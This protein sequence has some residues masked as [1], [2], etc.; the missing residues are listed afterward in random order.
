MP[1]REIMTQKECAEELGCHV[2]TIARYMDG[3]GLEYIWL[4]GKRRITRGH[5]E[6]FL[7]EHTTTGPLEPLDDEDDA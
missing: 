7:K 1:K 4:G 5:W 3:E 6:K 2:N